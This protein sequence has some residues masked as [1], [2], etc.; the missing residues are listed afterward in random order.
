MAT[1]N[2]YDLLSAIFFFYPEDEFENDREKIH[3]A[4][5][6]IRK[7]HFDLLRDFVFRQN[8]LFDRSKILDE[9]LAALQPE[10]LG[11]INPTLDLY[12]IKKSRLEML[13]EMDLKSS[14]GDKE[15]EIKKISTLLH[16]KMVNA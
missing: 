1:A 6:E 12:K 2:P 7:S 11:K 4:F 16:E 15:E 8:L 3:S 10:F 9:I 13:W 14:L 5:A